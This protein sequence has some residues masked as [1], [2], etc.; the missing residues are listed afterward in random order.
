MDIGFI[1]SG[2]KAGIYTL[3]EAVRLLRDEEFAADTLR[4]AGFD[5]RFVGIYEGKKLSSGKKREDISFTHA[6][7]R[8][9]R[10]VD[11]VLLKEYAE[12]FQRELFGE[13]KEHFLSLPSL[14]LEAPL[15]FSAPFAGALWYEFPEE[16]LEQFYVRS[17]YVH[18]DARKFGAGRK[19]IESV[20]E[21]FAPG[22]G[23]TTIGLDAPE[24]VVLFYRKLGFRQA[25]RSLLGFRTQGQQYLVKII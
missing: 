7:V 6:L 12:A 15:G 4:K 9:S 21:E 16:D 13:E 25:S 23:C 8:D 24:Q 10:D 18:L 5:P 11:K 14:V 17:L 2:Y 1:C 19:L 20:V 22:Y 3:P